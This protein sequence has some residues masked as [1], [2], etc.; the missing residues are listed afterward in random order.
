[1]FARGSGAKQNSS[2]EWKEFQRVMAKISDKLGLNYRV[3]DLSYPAIS[4][5]Q[6]SHAVG[7]WISAGKAF[8]FGR[9]VASGISSLKSYY[10]K[11]AASC[12]NTKWVLGGYSQGA[13]VA[14]EAVKSFR[15][16]NVVYVGLFGDP[17]LYLPE[18]RGLFPSACF[19]G[20]LSSYRIYV[21]NCRAYGGS[22]G[23]R[24]PYVSSG[25]TGKLG[26]WCNRQ[27]YVCGSSR[28]LFVNSGH[29]TYVSAG[30]ISWMGDI[31]YRRL[32][33]G[34]SAQTRAAFES[35]IY[36]Y[37]SQDEYM[38]QDGLRL[39]VSGSFSLAGEITDY[40]WTFG[41][42]SV[43]T[44]E[45]YLDWR[46]DWGPNEVTVVVIDTQDNTASATASVVEPEDEDILPSPDLSVMKSG[47]EIKV[48]WAEYPAEAEYLLLR[49]NGVDIDYADAAQNVVVLGDVED[50]ASFSAVWLDENLKLGEELVV[51]D[52]PVAEVVPVETGLDFN[53]VWPLLMLALFVGFLVVK[54]Y[55]PP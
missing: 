24:R 4:V 19:G 54:K 26:T 52:V 37:F 3:T 45:P 47:D 42:Q 43:F 29:M 17:Q 14:A 41:E 35:E 36:A 34:G 22:L 39:D 8:E 6:P 32:R 53:V 33:N 51:E 23:T 44:Q 25:L 5:R 7:A 27:D 21:P 10:T 15:A 50:V 55:L 38:L 2:A 30:E 11:V 28:V 40:L 31:V 16:S 1:M 20:A 18:G 12:P 13:M 46:E 49:V 48:Y 9:S